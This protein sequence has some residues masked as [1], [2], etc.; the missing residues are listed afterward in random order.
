[1]SFCDHEEL[2]NLKAIEKLIRRT[3]EVKSNPLPDAP[4]ETIQHKPRVAHEQKPQ[5]AHE[6]REPSHRH[7]APHRNSGHPR[8]GHHPSSRHPIHG[9]S[10]RGGPSHRPGGRRRR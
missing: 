7:P 9:G 8:S 4:A 1:V 5:T 3:I 6:H 10:R 2:P